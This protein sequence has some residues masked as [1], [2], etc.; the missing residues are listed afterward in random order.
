[1]TVSEYLKTLNATERKF[2]KKTIKMGNSHF[3]EDT[4]QM[5]NKP[6]KICSTLYVTRELKIKT[7][8]R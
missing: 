3:I 4:M 5:A 7:T 2:K 6:M 1:M 8:M